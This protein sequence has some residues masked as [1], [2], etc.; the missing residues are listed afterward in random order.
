M[1][2][3][4]ADFCHNILLSRILTLLYLQC[5]Y[6][7]LDVRLHFGHHENY[8][9]CFIIANFNAKCAVYCSCLLELSA[10]D[11]FLVIILWHK[12]CTGIQ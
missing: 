2:T 1:T 7:T 11:Y 8:L 12:N 4:R 3:S 6:Y 9:Q 10:Y 5:S